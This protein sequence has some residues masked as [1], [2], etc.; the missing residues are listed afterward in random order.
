MSKLR[1]FYFLGF[2]FLNSQVFGEE[3]LKNLPQKKIKLCDHEFLAWV[4]ATDES[5]Q[6]GLMNFRPLKSNE[7]M[8]FIFESEEER[9]FW[10]K[11]V[12]YDLDIAFFKKNKKLVSQKTM[13]GTS[14]LTQDIALPV[15]SSEGTAMYALEVAGG[16]LKKI[17]SKCTLK[18][19]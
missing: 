17:S 18:F 3:S 9:S 15:Y 12:P 2:I 5:R 1:A 16:G 10:M 13:K 14:P 4:A 7:A 19:N 8:L 6:K 11:N